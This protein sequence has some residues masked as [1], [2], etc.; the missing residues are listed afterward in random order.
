MFGAGMAVAATVT[1]IGAPD[2]FLTCRKVFRPGMHVSP[3]PAAA[4]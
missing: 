2:A 1:V 4:A 3:P